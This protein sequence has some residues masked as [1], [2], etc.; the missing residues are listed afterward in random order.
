MKFPISAIL[1]IGFG[2][3]FATPVNS[4]PVDYVRC[5]AMAKARDRALDDPSLLLEARLAMAKAWTPDAERRAI[6][7]MYRRLR[8]GQGSPY[9]V[10]AVQKADNIKA[11][12]VKSGCP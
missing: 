2:F 6:P 12:M 9:A 10:A 3:V 8:M 1:V 4:E 7:E 11:D 5:E